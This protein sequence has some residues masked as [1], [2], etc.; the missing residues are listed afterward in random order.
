M[1]HEIGD[2]ENKGENLYEWEAPTLDAK[3]KRVCA[4][5]NNGW[6]NEIEGRARPFLSSLIQ[7]HGRTLYREGQQRLATWAVKTAMML[8]FL[9]RGSFRTI[10]QGHYNQLFHRPDQPPETTQV[11]LSAVQEGTVCHHRPVRLGLKIPGVIPDVHGY[12]VTF[13]VGHAVFQIFGHEL[14]KDRAIRDTRDGRPFGEALMPIWPYER[15][16]EW[17]P[18]FVFSMAQL[19]QLIS[20]S[21]DRHWNFVGFPPAA[22]WQLP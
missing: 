7:G 5:C 1:L 2:P 15:A 16:V 20:D 6:M 19:G 10:P 14:G 9:A 12:G 8:A 22:E 11:W 17:P 4:Q 18:P 21:A 3:V 13:N